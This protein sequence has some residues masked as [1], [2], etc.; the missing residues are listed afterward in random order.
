MPLNMVAAG[1]GRLLCSP[2]SINK[3]Q[4]SVTKVKC[5]P[6][7]TGGI[8]SRHKSVQ[9]LPSLFENMLSPL[10]TVFWKHNQLV[11]PPPLGMVCWITA[12]MPYAEASHAKVSGRLVSLCAETWSLINRSLPFTKAPCSAPIHFQVTFPLSSLYSG[13]N[14]VLYCGKIP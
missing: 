14:T 10:D 3:G 11:S 2:K 9:A 1:V 13:A 7:N 8:S 4:W 5:L 12:P 6:T